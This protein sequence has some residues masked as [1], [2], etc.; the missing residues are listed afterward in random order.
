MPQKEQNSEGRSKL[1]QTWYKSPRLHLLYVHPYRN[2]A[3]GIKPQK[4]KEKKEIRTINKRGMIR[5]RE[6]E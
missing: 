5:G 6:G 1:G 4:E 2:L 3:T